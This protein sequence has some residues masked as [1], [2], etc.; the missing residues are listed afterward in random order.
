MDDFVYDLTGLIVVVLIFLIISYCVIR[1][2]NG[3]D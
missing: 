2:F 3:E 1:K